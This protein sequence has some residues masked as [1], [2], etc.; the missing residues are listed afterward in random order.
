[1]SPSRPAPTECTGGSGRGGPPYADAVRRR[2]LVAVALTA[3]LAVAGFAAATL[4][5]LRSRDGNRPPPTETLIL[6]RGAVSVVETAR[7]FRLG[8]AHG[9]WTVEKRCRREP[10]TTVGPGYV[11][12][13]VAADGTLLV[14]DVR[15]PGPLNDPRYGGL[16]AFGWHH[17]RGE[18]GATALGL[19]NA[20][21]VSGRQCARANGGFG[22]A[23]SRVLRRPRAGDLVPELTV[24]VDLTDAY[25]QPRPLVR[26]RYRYRLE[27]EALVSWVAVTTLCPA[28]RCGRTPL[29][30]FVKEPK[31][32]ASVTG[33]ATAETV[34]Y[35]A[36]GRPVCR[37]A[38]G[39]P[40]AGPV[41]ETGQCSANERLRVR[42]EDAGSC[43]TRVCLEVELR[44]AAGPWEGGALDRWAL[45]AAAR[46]A[47]GRRDTGSIDGVVWD[48]HAPS[49]AADVHR[50]WETVARRRSDGTPLAVSVLFAAWQGGRGAFDCEPLSRLFGPAG[51]T[52]TAQATY[53]LV[54]AGTDA[55]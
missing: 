10:R 26:V 21:E 47:L 17:A 55:R 33:G 31:L 38:G 12:R 41:L 13:L 27:P 36:A 1:M 15:E 32:V 45:A 9:T 16:G 54:F 5:V 52:Y 30:A 28:G 2:R 6:R 42:W 14:D 40:P 4:L 44:D 22:V 29:R 35:D 7:A 34:T 49:P 48:C 3:G 25:T 18:P 11:S 23:G 39:G 50:R 8:N 37:Y 43:S 19:A 53:R 20:W 46:P 51:E 24:E